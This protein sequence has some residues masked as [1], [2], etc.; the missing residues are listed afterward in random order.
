MSKRRV[1][2]ILVILGVVSSIG[3]LAWLY[4]YRNTGARL[5]GKASHAVKLGNAGGAARWR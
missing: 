1:I 3:G 5:L 2:V 4:W